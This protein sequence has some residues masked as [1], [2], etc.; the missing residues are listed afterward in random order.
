MDFAVVAERLGAVF[1]ASTGAATLLG[2]LRDLPAER[3]LFLVLLSA[4]AFLAT[5]T[6]TLAAIFT[7]R[8][9]PDEVFLVVIFLTAIGALGLEAAAIFLT[10]AAGFFSGDFETDFDAVLLGPAFAFGAWGAATGFCAFFVYTVVFDLEIDLAC[11]GGETDFLVSSLRV[12][13]DERSSL[14][15]SVFF[16]VYLGGEAFFF[17]ADA[18]DFFGL[19][20][21]FSALL[22][23]FSKGLDLE[24]SK[25]ELDRLIT[26]EILDSCLRVA[27]SSRLRT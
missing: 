25:T 14:F 13:T 3:L 7:P 4:T 16:P 20:A 26:L 8:F 12:V 5:C 10:G 11:L 17:G 15:A 18:T 24:R 9:L 27:F 23:G 2:L 22:L 21:Y 1:L 19:A 6:T